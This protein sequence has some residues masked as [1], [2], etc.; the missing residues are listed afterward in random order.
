MKVPRVDSAPSL[1][2]LVD[3]AGSPRPVPPAPGSTIQQPAP[4][5]HPTVPPTAPWAGPLGVPMPPLVTLDGSTV[6][7]PTD[8]TVRPKPP[9]APAS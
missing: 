4:P 3:L 9:K 1:A 7:A 2:G 5:A 8:G 6:P